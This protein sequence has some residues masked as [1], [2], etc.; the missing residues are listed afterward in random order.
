VDLDRIVVGDERHQPALTDP[1]LQARVAAVE[2]GAAGLQGLLVGCTGAVED[3][4]VE[5]GTEED[6]VT[7]FHR[8]AVGRHDAHEVVV[9]HGRRLR[10]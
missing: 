7:G 9:A 4:L 2:A 1:L 10:P 6:E 5:A 3:D 8:D